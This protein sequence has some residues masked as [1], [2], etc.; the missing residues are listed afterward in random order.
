MANIIYKEWLP[1]QPELGN[2][3]LIRAEN[4]LPTDTSWTQ[5]SPLTPVRSGSFTLPSLPRG[6]FCAEV[7]TI[8]PPYVYYAAT[9]DAI[10]MANAGVLSGTFNSRSSGWITMPAA[11]EVDFAQ[12]EDLVFAARGQ[13]GLQ[14][15]TAGSSS[16]FTTVA[17]MTGNRDPRYVFVVGQFLV[18]ANLGSSTAHPASLQW[19]AIGDPTNFPT[20]GSATAIATQS[21]EQV[22]NLADGP[23]VGGFG[24]DQFGMVLQT[25][26][27][28]RMTY[29]GP[30]VVFQFDRIDMNKGSC[31][32]YGAA[33]SGNLMH[34][35][36]SDGFYKS[37][38]V[39][40]APIGEGRVN[41]TFVDSVGADN[42]PG[43]IT[44]TAIVEAAFDPKTKNI[45]WSYPE[46][47]TTNANRILSYSTAF[48]KFGYCQQVMR[49][50]I[51]PSPSIQTD[52][53]YAF[54]SSN[55]LCKFAGTAGAAVFETGDMEF[56]EGGRAYMDAV[57]PHVQYS[58]TAPAIGVRFAYRDDLGP[59][60]TYSATATPLARTG[61]A[62]TRVDGKYLRVEV[63]I[64]GNFEKVSG[65]EHNAVPS[66]GA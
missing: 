39:S 43:A 62:N 61:F 65:F 15:Q 53:L 47:S 66:G 4:A 49:T 40:I 33:A 21:G 36:A 18:V 12:F 42:T 37:D 6:G 22:F 24:G 59:A 11:N 30:P 13:D 7:G 46:G 28:T 14:V 41:K 23:I 20:P 54:N 51:E 3:G 16:N 64:N 25:G 63:N 58:G 29:V 9:N 57:K 52:G 10:Y 48:D 50:F 34:F 55:V 1:D 17:G 60:P 35:F 27:I 32:R 8:V 45:F 5:F 2:P 56:F 38:G 19:S 31:R 26:A 44:A